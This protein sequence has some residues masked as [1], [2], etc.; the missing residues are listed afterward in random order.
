MSTNTATLHGQAFLGTIEPDFALELKA[1]GQRQLEVIVD[2][3]PDHHRQEHRVRFA[4]DQ[5]D[6]PQV[7]EKCHGVL[8]KYPIRG[9]APIRTLN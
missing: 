9:Q 3:R 7:I 6:L 5:S 1:V 4:I 8:R 2:I